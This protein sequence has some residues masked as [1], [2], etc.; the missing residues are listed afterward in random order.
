MA[1][2]AAAA[3]CRRDPRRLT[4]TAIV[5]VIPTVDAPMSHSSGA[6]P[7]RMETVAIPSSR[8][9]RRGLILHRGPTLPLAA[10]TPRLRARIPLLLAAVMAVEGAM[11]ALRVAIVEEALPAMAVAVGVMA[12]VEEAVAMGEAVEAEATT[13]VEAAGADLIAVVA[14]AVDLTAV[15]EAEATAEEAAATRITN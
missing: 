5:Q 11:E 4:T 14:E 3:A 2:R 15:A 7:P 9:T 13:A 1:A 8:L 10:V 12:V 6:T